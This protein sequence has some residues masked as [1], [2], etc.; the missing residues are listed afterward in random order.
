M[1]PRI[2]TACAITASV[3]PGLAQRV[4]AALGQRQVDRAAAL[5]ALQAWIRAALAAPAPASPARQQRRQQRAGQAGA[6]NGDDRR[7]RAHQAGAQAATASAKAR[8]SSKL[9]YSGAGE[10]RMTSGSR[11]SPITPLRA[12]VFEQCAPALAPADH[13][14]RQLAAA[15]ARVR[16]A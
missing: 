8:T 14:Q 12:Q 4:Q 15:R 1:R 7:T 16:S 13:A 2:I 5:E 3:Q 9:L 10:M 6:G 11:Q